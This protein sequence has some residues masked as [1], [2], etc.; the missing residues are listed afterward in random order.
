MLFLL[1]AGHALADYP[2]QG[3]FMAEAKNRNTAI[4]K[5]YWPWALPSHGLIH[6]G[7]VAVITGSVL[8]GVAESVAHTA[9]DWL[10]CEGRISVH[11]DQSIHVACKAFWVALVLL[12]F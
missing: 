7:L 2:L 1:L 4:G 10:R 11:T 3:P 8:L 9:T 6:G 5:L 12:P